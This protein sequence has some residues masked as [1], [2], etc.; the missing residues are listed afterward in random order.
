M[1]KSKL[2]AI[3]LEQ[4]DE[5]DGLVRSFADYDTYWLSGYVH[6]FKL[7]G[8][9][10]PLLMHYEGADGT[11]GINVVMLR[12]I[13]DDSRFEGLIEHGR[14]FDFSSP[15]GYGGWIIEG[16]DRAGLFAAYERWCRRTGI[17]SE[18]VRFHP[19]VGN[20]K[21]C[22][23]F[24]D[25][26]RLGEV[27]QMDLTS[28]EVIWSNMTSKNRNMV[29]K[30]IRSGVKVYNGRFPEVFQQFKVIYDATMDKDHADSYYYFDEA[31][32]NS[33]LEKLPQNAQVFWAEYDSKMIAASIM[34]SCNGMMNY[35]LSGSLKEYSG[36]AATNLVLYEAALWGCASGCRT[37]YLG[38]G[39][40]SGE[41]NLFKF[42]RSFYKGD[43]TNFHIGKKVFL[44]NEYT[45]LLS[46]RS[47][48]DESAINSSF[49][50]IYRG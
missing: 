27:V 19:M 3:G 5:W 23:D 34:L 30:A 17:V 49:F 9:G 37:L 15:Y 2:A 6:A 48:K 10:E 50:P 11:R 13:A 22:V 31:F 28:P 7:H 8:D 25:V 40:G 1:A 24:Y 35:H 29:R 43:L 4:A 47:E 45:K 36:L 20:H 46:L 12:D 42:K 33:I 26:V 38:G 14:F 32:Y 18:F 16:D 41:D 21:S 44:H 39:V